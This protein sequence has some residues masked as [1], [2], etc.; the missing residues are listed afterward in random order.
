MN[1]LLCYS[2]IISIFPFHYYSFFF[3]LCG[4]IFLSCLRLSIIGFLSV[5]LLF[6]VSLLRLLYFSP[7]L[8]SSLYLLSPF[9]FPFLFFAFFFLLFFFSSSLSLLFSSS[10]VFTFLFPHLCHLLPHPHFP[11]SAPSHFPPISQHP[12]SFPLSAPLLLLITVFLFNM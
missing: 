3:F 7:F 1:R 9:S 11:L 2:F 5:S 4:F 10:L 12:L 8:S 6:V